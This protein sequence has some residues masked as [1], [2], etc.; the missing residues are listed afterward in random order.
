MDVANGVSI[1]CGKFKTLCFHIFITK[2]STKDYLLND[3]HK[4]D[5]L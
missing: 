3:D 5:N 1:L 4:T 2:M